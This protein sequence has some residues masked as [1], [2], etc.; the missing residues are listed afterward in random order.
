MELCDKYLHEMIKIEPT[1]NDFFLF[2]EYL[3]KK[4]IQPDTYSE[5]HYEK[6]HTLDKKYRDL[7]DQKEE[8]TFSDRILLRDIN[9]NIH[10][11][12]DYEIYMY[13]PI[14]LNDNILVDYVTECSGSG[15]YSFEKRKDYLD[16]MIKLFND[17][18]T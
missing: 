10:M 16:F 3:D 14:N 8:K 6:L 17:I 2:E 4:G 11:E 1:M 18:I 13:M 7:L 5:K 9:H 15:N 12:L